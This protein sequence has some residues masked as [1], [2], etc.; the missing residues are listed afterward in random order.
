M[1]TK[2]AKILTLSLA[3]VL[4]LGIFSGCDIN[5][6]NTDSHNADS[7]NN[8]SSSETAPDKWVLTYKNCQYSDEDPSMAVLSI[9]YEYRYDLSGHLIYEKESTGILDYIGYDYKYDDKGN[10]I[11]KSIKKVSGLDSDSV[12][13]STWTYQY[14]EN[15]NC[16]NETVHWLNDNSLDV[17]DYEYNDKGNVIKAHNKVDG[18]YTFEIT[19]TYTLTYENGNCIQ[20]EIL[21]EH[22]NS[23]DT[24]TYYMVY[25]YEYDENGNMSVSR[26]YTDIDNVDEAK[27]PVQINGRY[28]KLDSTTYYTYEKLADIATDDANINDVDDSPVITTTTLPETTTMKNFSNLG[29]YDL[30]GYDKWIEIDGY[31]F[32]EGK[33]YTKNTTYLHTYVFYDTYYTYTYRDD[34]MWSDMKEK[35]AYYTIIDNDVLSFKTYYSGSWSITDRKYYDNMLIIKTMYDGSEMWLAPVDLIDWNKSPEKNEYYGN[36]YYFK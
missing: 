29:W 28:Y 21:N 30:M 20:E 4:I 3:V 16:I 23:F 32:K 8:D 36:N 9:E 2:I 33:V 35:I 19:K 6:N 1:K 31:S 13:Y 26:Y 27:N 25:Q 7:E 15:G 18:V 22:T 34:G 14:D 17:T 5:T 24:T 11:A 12:D 10:V